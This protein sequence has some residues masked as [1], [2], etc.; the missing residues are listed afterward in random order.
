MPV[1]RLR[2]DRF[3]TGVNI[4]GRTMA[5]FSRSKKPDE[6]DDKLTMDEAELELPAKPASRP[7]AG[8]VVPSRPAAVPPM[9]PVENRASEARRPEPRPAE[10]RAMEGKPVADTTRPADMARRL[11]DSP[12]PTPSRPEPELRKLTVGREIS[13]QGEITHCDHLV[14]EG[15]VTANLAGCHA[16]EIMESG[17]YKG[18]VDIDQIEVR[19]LFEGTMNVSGRLLIRSTG[20]VVGKVSYGQIEIEIGGQVSGEVQ[21]QP[22]QAKASGKGAAAAADTAPAGIL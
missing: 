1:R 15:S 14:V 3:G 21:A 22:Q 17:V 11:V 5:I 9:R 7:S 10:T 8:G 18:S 19:G 6:D 20:R 2:R 4:A 16:V 13:L 12:T